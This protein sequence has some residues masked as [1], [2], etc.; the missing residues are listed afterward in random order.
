M[1]LNLDE[2]VNYHYDEFP[3]Q[4]VD[5]GKFVEQ[6]YKGYRCNCTL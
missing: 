3:P 1:E 5:Y 2:A 6:A 4:K